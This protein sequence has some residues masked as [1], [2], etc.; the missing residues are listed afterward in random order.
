MYVWN[1]QQ[2]WG[3]IL[4]HTDCMETGKKPNLLQTSDF[5]KG[6]YLV[7]RNYPVLHS[8]F[9]T[10]HGHDGEGLPRLQQG[11]GPESNV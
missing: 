1:F 10:R 7:I 2:F 5:G 6:N 4:M 9:S 3:I 11:P 8:Y